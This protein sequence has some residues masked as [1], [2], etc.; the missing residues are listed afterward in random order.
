M[1]VMGEDEEVEAYFPATQRHE[2]SAKAWAKHLGAK[3]LY[4]ML[5]EDEFVPESVQEFL[6]N[7]DRM[8][9]K[10]ATDATGYDPSTGE[11]FLEQDS[12]EDDDNDLVAMSKEYGFD[13]S[14]LNLEEAEV[15]RGSG[16]AA[17]LYDHDNASTGTMD[18][19]AY[20]EKNYSSRVNGFDAAAKAATPAQQAEQPAATEGSGPESPSHH[21]G[22]DGTSPVDS[23]MD[24]ASANS[25]ATSGRDPAGGTSK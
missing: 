13:L 18:T 8:H 10:I 9:R 4:K 11:V 23:P 7:F 12:E 21:E 24:S 2:A 25:A 14:E 5:L 6:N 17:R 1:V 15:E 19:D 16:A 20:I 22:T 3:V